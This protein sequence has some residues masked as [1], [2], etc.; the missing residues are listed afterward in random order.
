M[1]TIENIGD[2]PLVIPECPRLEKGDT[3]QVSSYTANMVR[4]NPNIRILSDSLQGVEAENDT[5]T[6]KSKATTVK[7]VE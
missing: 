3:A 1:V 2:E 6:T 4:N 5:K 7:G